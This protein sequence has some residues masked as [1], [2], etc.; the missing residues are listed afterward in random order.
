MSLLALA[1]CGGEEP[2]E[3]PGA[4]AT[5]LVRQLDRGDS[6]A[7]WDALHPLHQD[8]IT[9]TRY[10]SCERRDPIE[11]DVTRV[12]VTGVEDERWTIPGQDAE[13]DSKAVSLRLTLETPGAAGPQ[14]FDL[15]VHLFDVDGRWAW[16]IGPVDYESYVSGACPGGV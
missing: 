13:T 8:T 1:G 4:F 2:E 12:Q 3:D 11:G 5:A 9:R 6:G 16:V 15:T 7:A 10:V 14:P